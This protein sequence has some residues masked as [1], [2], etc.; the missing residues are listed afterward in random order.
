[1]LEGDGAEAAGGID[2]AS[3]QLE[4]CPYSPDE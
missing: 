3:D 1:M 4:G 2:E